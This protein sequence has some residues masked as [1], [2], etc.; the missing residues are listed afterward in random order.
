MSSP[1]TYDEFPREIEVGGGPNI[2]A[3][4]QDEYDAF[5]ESARRNSE[6]LMRE[7]IDREQWPYIVALYNTSLDRP[8]APLAVCGPFASGDEATA[9]AE[10]LTAR[11]ASPDVVARAGR[12]PSPEYTDEWVNS[13][14]FDI[15]DGDGA[16]R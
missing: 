3:H 5:I 14:L 8:T 6:I 11:T 4:S 10:R 7:R 12:L 1:T 13:D 16:A 15:V 2:V 9:Y